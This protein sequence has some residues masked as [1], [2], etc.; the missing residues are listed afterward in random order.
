MTRVGNRERASI[1]LG[2][3]CEIPWKGGGVAHARPRAGRPRLLVHYTARDLENIGCLRAP[4]SSSVLR[5]F[6]GFSLSVSQ[7]D[8]AVAAA[9]G[10]GTYHPTAGLTSIIGPP[11]QKRSTESLV[12]QAFLSTRQSA[13][14]TPA[15]IRN[16]P[17]RVVI[18]IS[19]NI[20]YS[21][22][23]A[24]SRRERFRLNVGTNPRVAVF[25][26][27]RPSRAETDAYWPGR[28]RCVAHGHNIPSS[29]AYSTD[30][31]YEP[32]PFGRSYHH[33]ARAPP[34]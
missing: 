15:Y 16:D 27:C 11:M 17:P 28:R 12:I 25:S 14:R 9:A 32:A 21:P 33:V 6:L 3:A 2:P 5:R 22:Y 34:S 23:A 31:R 8:G 20:T 10:V 26:A 1:L 18:A 13:R 30:F 29:S 24:E 19:N 4:A 7:L